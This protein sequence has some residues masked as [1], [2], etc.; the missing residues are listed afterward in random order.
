MTESDTAILEY[1]DLLVLIDNK[2]R[3]YLVTLK[4]G[5]EFHTH[6]GVLPHSSIVGNLDGSMLETSGGHLFRILRPS[7][8]DFIINMPRGAQVIYPKDIGAILMLA[9]IG[10]GMRVFESGLGSGALS[11]AL[12][13]AGADILGYEIR[14]DF[15]SRA[16][17][18]VTKFLGDEA[19]QRYDVHIQDSYETIEAEGLDRVVL[20]LPEPWNVVPHAAKAM[21]PGATFV[22]YSPSIVQSA[23]VT[24]AL[25]AHRFTETNTME[26]LHRSWHIKGDAVRPDHRMVAHT[27]FLTKGRL[28]AS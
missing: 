27:A 16:K 15:A 18:N 6:G 28:L 22:S 23:K 26:V 10:P 25:R 3:S 7:L 14:E 11:T 19:L 9:D 5:E 4:E 8:S 13:R 12:L 2:R 17:K 21:R 1:G 20:D 24:E